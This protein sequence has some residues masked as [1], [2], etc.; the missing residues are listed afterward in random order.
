MHITKEKIDEQNALLKVEL[1]SSD[2]SEPFQKALKQYSKQINLPGFRAGKVPVSLVK[3]RYGKSLLAEEINKLLNKSIQDYIVENKLDIL[4]SPIPSEKHEEKGDWDNPGTF[5]FFYDLGL[6]PEID[7]KISKEDVFEY[8]PIIIED[9]MLDEEVNNISRRY[10]KMSDAEV[11]GEND[12]LIGDFIELDENDQIKEGGILSQSTISLEF[13][14][15]D[16]RQ[17][18]VGKSVA[19][20]VVVDPYKVS[21]DHDDLARMLHV[22]HEETHDINTNFKFRI[23]EIKRLEPAELNEEFFQKIFPAGDVKNEEEFRARIKEDLEKGFA[24]DSDRLF[25]REV[26]NKLIA[27]YNPSLP[28]EFLKRWILLTNE[29]P[30]TAEE[31]EKDYEQYQKGLQWQLIFNQMIEKHNLR[32][33]EEEAIERTKELMAQQYAQYGIPRPDDDELLNTAMRV[34]SNKDESR[35]VFDM[36]YD[37]KLIAFIREHATVNEKPLTYEEISAKAAQG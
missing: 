28:D 16:E 7:V 35:R 11:A 27:D 13:I 1:D 18:F 26:T 10:G 32:V 29:K 14:D 2:Y 6:A 23:D 21:R 37:E 25:K 8:N 30:I 9:K 3:Q 24:Q 15:K 22:S 31:L 33:E 34:L 17:K 36:L 12:M 20:E 4:G 5:E 19:D